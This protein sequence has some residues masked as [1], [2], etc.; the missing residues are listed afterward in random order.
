[1]VCKFAAAPDGLLF[2]MAHCMLCIEP[3]QKCEA[4]IKGLHQA[5]LEAAVEEEAMQPDKAKMDA[6]AHLVQRLVQLQH[7][8]RARLPRPGRSRRERRSDIGGGRQGW[9]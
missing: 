6:F 1:M 8:A 9:G 7:H 3:R 2:L 4:D 5:S